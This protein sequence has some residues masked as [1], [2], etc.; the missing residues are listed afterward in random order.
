MKREM[1]K[2]PVE[3]FEKAETKE[4]LEDWLMANNPVW[5]AETQIRAKPM[6]EG[7]VLTRRVLRRRWR[8]E[9]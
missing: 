2:I 9:F 6:R 7:L 3:L 5:I 4:N 8:R 1:L